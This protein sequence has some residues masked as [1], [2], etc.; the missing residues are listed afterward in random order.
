MKQFHLAES[1]GWHG[2]LLA[3]YEDQGE[4]IFQFKYGEIV[5][6]CLLPGASALIGKPVWLAKIYGK[7]RIGEMSGEEQPRPQAA[8]LLKAIEEIRGDLL[9]KLDYD[10]D[11]PAILVV[12]K[13]GPAK[14]EQI[15]MLCHLSDNAARRRLDILI[16]LGEIEHET[17]SKTV[18]GRTYTYPTKR[19]QLAEK[20]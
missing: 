8:P 2:P 4:Q 13:D 14:T 6:D 1:E 3:I 9:C 20:R 18:N 7:Y 15:A 19:W 17:I 12:L 10:K 5:V 16:D 11:L